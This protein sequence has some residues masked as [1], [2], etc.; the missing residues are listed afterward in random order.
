MQWR[1]ANGESGTLSAT[2]S[3]TIINFP[4]SV[5]GTRVTV[6]ARWYRG[7]GVYSPPGPV[8][9]DSVPMAS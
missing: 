5:G 1:S 9:T 4:R 2:K 6:Q 8:V 3:P 7:N